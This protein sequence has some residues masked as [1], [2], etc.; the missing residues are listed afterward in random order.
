MASILAL[1]MS[2]WS[3]SSAVT[4]AMLYASAAAVIWSNSASRFLGV[5]FLESLRPGRSSSP[6]RMTAAA[7]TGPARGPAPASS[8]PQRVEKP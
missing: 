8:T 5:S 3:I 1:R 6:G 4:K 7:Y 2:I